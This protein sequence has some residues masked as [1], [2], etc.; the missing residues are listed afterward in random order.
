MIQQS[1]CLTVQGTD[2]IKI[3]GSDS[4]KA[5]GSSV[6]RDTAVQAPISLRASSQTFHESKGQPPKS[7]AV[8]WSYNQ[9]IHSRVQQSKCTIGRQPKTPAVQQFKGTAIQVSNS[10]AVRRSSSPRVQQSKGPAN[11]GPTVRKSSNV[12]KGPAVRKSSK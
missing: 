1:S 5:Q 8:H 7:P 12:Y 10:T 2:S 3:Q 9:D 11:Y 4:T 6:Q